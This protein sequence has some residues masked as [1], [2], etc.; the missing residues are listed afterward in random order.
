[1]SIAELERKVPY[2][3]RND[4][5]VPVRYGQRHV[6]SEQGQLATGV[7]IHTLTSATANP[8]P[9]HVLGPSANVSKCLCP[10]IS[11]ACR[12]M[13]SSR[14]HRAG[15][16]CFASG[17]HNALERL[18]DA[19]G[20]V[21]TVPRGIEKWVIGVGVNG[22]TT[23]WLRGIM[24]SSVACSTERGGDMY[25][26]RIGR[27]IPRATILLGGH[28]SATFRA[29]PHRGMEVRSSVV[30]MSDLR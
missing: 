13:P 12:G 2:E 11:F 4:D 22:V 6:R 28:V 26:A 3:D 10:C 18:I 23:G 9:K 7:H 30:P 24:S 29:L 25:L 14:V 17:P 21:T 20:T 16:N 5:L 19:M 15:L 27:N 8:F 1:M